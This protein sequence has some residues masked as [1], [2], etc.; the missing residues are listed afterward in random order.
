MQYHPDKNPSAEAA[1]RI[2]EINEAYDVLGDAYRKIEYDRRRNAVIFETPP[3]PRHRDPAYHRSHAPRKPSVSAQFL[4]MQQSIPYIIKLIYFS[5][6]FC[7]FL[8]LD[9]VLPRIIQEEVVVD[10]RAHI[11]RSRGRNYHSSDEI[12]T[13]KGTSFEIDLDD[14]GPLADGKIIFISYTRIQ[15]I[16]I[17]VTDRASFSIRVPVTIFGNFIFAPIILVIVSAMGYCYRKN[18]SIAFNFGTVIF[19]IL[20]LC[21]I[22]LIIS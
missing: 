11:A 1:I 4:M 3:A 16:P 22:F 5:L 10:K 21:F 6:I 15:H 13:N 8:T 9:F 2:R 18:V 17:R 14:T 12:Y 19:F 20:L 7:A